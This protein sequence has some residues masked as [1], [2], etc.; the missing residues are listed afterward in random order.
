[1]KR[2]L[3][4]LVAAGVS[5][6]ALADN[7]KYVDLFMGTAGD[8]G[9][10]TP[11]AQLPL[12]LASVCPDSNPAWHGGY[13][14]EV[15]AIS[16]IS[17]TRISGT[18]GNGTGGN[19]RIRPAAADYAL[20]IV[21]GTEKAV[22]GYYETLL[23]N[24]VSV[25]L[26]ATS[27]TALERY[28][29]PKDAPKVMSVD[30][31]SAMDPRRSK[32]SWHSA[33]ANAFE[34]WCMTST[35]GNAGAYTLWFRIES[36]EPFE[37][38]DS[39]STTA[40]VRF[41]GNVKDVEIRVSL[42][43]I[44][45]KTAAE[46]M[47]LC[48]GRSFDSVRK[49]AARA[50][51]EVLSKVDVKGSTDEQRILF[52]T[53]LYR[54][55]LS[56]LY[57]TSHD[58]RYLG[59][60]GQ[61][62]DCDGWTYYSGWS[63]W[64]TYRTKFPMYSLLDPDRMSDMCRSLVSLYCTGKRNWATL[65]ECVPTVRTE[66]SQVI[67]LDAWRKGVRGFDMSLA[68]PGMEKEY[69]DGLVPKSRQ[70]LT[71]NAPDQ[72]M[73]TIYDLWAMSGI[74]GIIGNGAAAGKYGDEASDLFEKTWKKEFMTITDKFAQMK[75]NGMYQGTR[76]QYRWAMPVYADRMKE[77][78]GEETLADQLSEFFERHLFNQGNEPDIQTPFM[79]NL[80]GH[81]ERTDSLVHAL[82]TDDTM[83]HLYGGNAEYPE[84]FVGRAFQDKV[85]GYALEMDED[86]GTMSAWYM[87][88]Q[89]GFYPVCVGTDTYEMFTPLF[90]KVV[91]HL[92]DHDVTIRRKCGEAAS[93]KVTVDGKPLDSWTITHSQ[94]TG[95]RKI[96]FE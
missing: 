56:P 26:T 50:W 12:G 30:F 90:S 2:I 88:C 29:Y 32:C 39:T 34:G 86:D 66:H 72:K 4:L 18:G 81:P 21:K 1:M 37:I 83:V 79:F 75:G 14:Y 89:M 76:W 62:H 96:V 22:P 3:T 48:S 47:A 63:M 70:G 16:G 54:M 73:E 60:D 94:L 53:S 93:E 6:A 57:A 85:D 44:D 23:N 25:R 38:S 46:E 17:V 35:V 11:A 36:S 68:F 82:L 52:Y 41:A 92:K 65:S 31:N 78:V 74:A 77:W 58:G 59:T 64:D 9:Q 40:A 24:G 20:E 61:V 71:R 10:V 7:S 42:S 13:D 45:G 67:L 43:P 15:P 19:L 51:S 95:A 80:F 28:S 27:N 5:M 8:H 87:F 49:D 91:L 55:Y 69:S 33:G 84:P